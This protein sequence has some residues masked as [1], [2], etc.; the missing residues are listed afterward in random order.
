MGFL[1]SM[2]EAGKDVAEQQLGEL[3]QQLGQEGGS[4]QDSGWCNQDFHSV[5]SVDMNNA[6]RCPVC[7]GYKTIVKTISLNQHQNH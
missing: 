1:D 5:D 7:W 2:M 4:H 3:L 6:L